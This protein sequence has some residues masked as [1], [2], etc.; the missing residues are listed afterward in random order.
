R[1]AAKSRPLFKPCS[2]HSV[3]Q[4][5][6]HRRSHFSA[7]CCVCVGR[8]WPD[9]VDASEKTYLAQIVSAQTGLPPADAEKRVDE[10]YA[11]AIRAVDKARRA[12]VVAALATAT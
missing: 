1:C 6:S 8:S 5:R 7:F 10:A 3:P 2:I 12:S 4:L 11:Q 9:S